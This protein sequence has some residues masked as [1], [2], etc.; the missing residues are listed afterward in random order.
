VRHVYHIFA[1]LSP[2]RDELSKLLNDRGVATG[3]H[4]PIPVHLQ[5]CF[6]FLGHKPGSFP[7]SERVAAEELSLPM[8]AELTDAQIDEVANALREVNK[9]L[10]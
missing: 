10:T 8:F 2:K 5:P 3:F 1:V 6:A 4:Y 7:V 9:G